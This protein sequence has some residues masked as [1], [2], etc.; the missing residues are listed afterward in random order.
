MT[1]TLINL[2]REDQERVRKIIRK[3]GKLYITELKN[4]W[5]MQSPKNSIKEPKSTGSIS[6]IKV[7]LVG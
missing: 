7:R 3:L 2:W 6:R 4:Q 5:T 1:G